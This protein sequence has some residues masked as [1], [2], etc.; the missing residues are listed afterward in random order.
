MLKIGVLFGGNSGEHDVSKCSAASVCTHL[1]KNKYEVIAIGIDRDGRWYPQK[2][3]KFED[4]DGFG[5]ILSLQK[6]G[7]WLV[8]HFEDKE[9]IFTLHNIETGEKISVDLVFPVVHGKHCED[10]ML[11][12]LLELASVPYIGS[13]VIGSAIGMDK[14]VAKR[15]LQHADIPVV[16]WITIYKHEWIKNKEV[17]VDK[18]KNE[19]GLPF[20]A[21]PANEGSSVGIYKVKEISEIIENIDKVFNYDQ[22]I[23]VEKSINCR[24]IE[25]S[26]LGNEEPEVSVCGEVI[27]N[28]EFYSYDAKY[29]DSNG[30][31]L[32]IP[33]KI[34][35]QVADQITKCAKNAYKLLCLKGMS[36]IDFFLDKDNNEIYLNEVNS[37]PGFT[38]ISMYPK[39]WDFSGLPYKDLLD[40]L[41]ELA[42]DRHK[43]NI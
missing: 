35:N 32:E 8:N 19:I 7:T 27:S 43:K 30:A 36:R 14:D 42:L 37:L 28:H 21:K 18:I 20:F 39:L 23:L 3:I 11:Q 1:D 31:N 29:L 40:K 6:N 2:E 5:K 12:G 33:A 15:I 38:S 22:K 10:G 16:P 13:D 4:T 34:D 9:N 25:C 26:V 17:I 41:I 24:E